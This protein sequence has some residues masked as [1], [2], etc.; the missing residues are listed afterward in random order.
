MRIRCCQTQTSVT[1][2]QHSQDSKKFRTRRAHG[3]GECHAARMREGKQKLMMKGE[4]DDVVAGTAAPS[5]AREKCGAVVGQKRAGL[6]PAARRQSAVAMAGQAGKRAPHVGSR[7][8]R[9]A[10]RRLPSPVAWRRLLCWPRCSWRCF[11]RPAWPARWQSRRAPRWARWG[12]LPARQTGDQT[13]GKRGRDGR[14]GGQQAAGERRPEA[15]LLARHLTWHRAGR[16]RVHHRAAQQEPVA[17]PH[18][19]ALLAPP[20]AACRHRPREPSPARSPPSACSRTSARSP[21]EGA[22][23]QQP[24]VVAGQRSIGVE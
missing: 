23:G 22:G 8:R 15:M 13:A 14:A 20:P 10:G 18:S 6:R 16:A 19:T 5:I 1:Q 17:A 21:A 4:L 12:R 2:A 7:G 3:C 9:Q 24:H 11:T